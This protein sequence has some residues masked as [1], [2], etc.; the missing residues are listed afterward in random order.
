M[1]TKTYVRALESSVI[2]NIKSL[3]KLVKLFICKASPATVKISFE[4]IL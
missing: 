2:F 1:V 4:I 3:I